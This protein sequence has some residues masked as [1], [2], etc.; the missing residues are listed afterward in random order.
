MLLQLERVG[1][2][3]DMSVLSI[4]SRR[5]RKFTFP[6]AQLPLYRNQAS[7]KCDICFQWKLDLKTIMLF[8]V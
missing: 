5:S 2:S 4:S 7:W 8:P 6:K 3:E 1:E